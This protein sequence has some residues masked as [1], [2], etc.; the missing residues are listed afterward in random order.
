M[1][2]FAHGPWLVWL[3]GSVAGAACTLATDFDRSRVIEHDRATCTDAIDNDDNGLADCQDW[4]CLPVR[5]CCT[6]PTVVLRDRFESATCADTPCDGPPPAC[7]GLDP[8]VWQ[9]WG[10]PEPVVCEGSL[11]PRKI[12]QCYDIGV[13]SLATFALEPGLTIGAGLLGRPE[14]RGQLEIGLT[15]QAQILGSVDP[16][17][18]IDPV[19]TAI[20][21]LQ[22]ADAGGFRLVARFDERDVGVSPIVS[23]LDRHDIEIA[24]R[25]D[26]RVHYALDGQTFANSPTD[27]PIVEAPRPARL[28]LAGRSLAARFDDVQVTTGTQCDDPRAWTATEPFLA[29]AATDQAGAWDDFAVFAPAAVRDPAGALRVFYT[30]CRERLGQCDSLLTGLGTATV[31]T[32]G[33][34]VRDASCPIMGPAM[35]T[36]DG[37]LE[38]PFVNDYNN[39]FEVS[40]TRSGV[41]L[42]AFLSLS[43]DGDEIMAI[44]IGMDGMAVEGADEDRVRTGAA[45]AWDDYEVCCPSAVEHAGTVYLWYAGRDGASSPWRVGLAT[46]SDGVRFVKH[47]ENP[48]LREGESGAFDNQGVGAPSVVR[49]E[50]RGLWRMWYAARGLLGIVSVGYA[51]STDGVTWQKY[52]DNPVVRPEDFG[53]A[54]MGGPEVLAEDGQLRLWLDGEIAGAPGRRIYGLGNQGAPHDEA[55]ADEPRA[56]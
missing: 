24:I 40:V 55:A 32:T 13:A 33:A 49:D 28:I 15:F 38:T 46:S 3:L 27:Q 14:T 35:I 1:R 6:I 51:I 10:T 5:E 44:R 25:S 45:G 8:A 31:S 16:C 37:G 7:D 41:N 52:P 54:G 29:L 43:R 22:V 53:L 30:G 23:D 56:P 47:A 17:D 39:L 2:R 26:R 11:A 19:Q 42:R 36:C 48:V 34:I 50:A 9:S 12:E 18:I 21:I 4:G 20:A